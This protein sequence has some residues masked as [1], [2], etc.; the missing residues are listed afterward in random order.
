LNKSYLRF[1]TEYFA[2]IRVQLR[3]R[4]F[5]FDSPKQPLPEENF[6]SREAVPDYILF[7]GRVVTGLGS[8]II[9]YVT[10]TN[11]E[12]KRVTAA[13]EAPTPVLIYDVADR[14]ASILQSLFQ[15]KSELPP[16]HSGIDLFVLAR[17]DFELG[18]LEPVAFLH[19]LI[20]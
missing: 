10:A 13:H 9:G 7:R 11:P 17:L 3:Y 6:S 16:I 14:I 5:S 19:D 8:I 12:H 18:G 1:G 2:K 20:I 4:W 15:P